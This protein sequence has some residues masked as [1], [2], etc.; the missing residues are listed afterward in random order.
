MVEDGASAN[1]STDR[2]MVL[3]EPTRAAIWEP[4]VHEGPATSSTLARCLALSSGLTGYRL[5][6]LAAFGLVRELKE[7]GTRRERWWAARPAE[8]QLSSAPPPGMPEGM[9]TLNA[10][11]AAMELQRHLGY[12][13]R[14]L[15][16]EDPAEAAWRGASTS[17][18]LVV[19]L[20]LEQ[21][22]E[23]DADV[24]ALIHKW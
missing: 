13:S 12:W 21:M 1:G 19:E 7:R 23:L 20:S 11:M 8:L 16:T 6:R 15:R 18:Q 3:T 9:E 10:Q 2:R 17:D 4:L 24:A 22:R 5:R 14:E